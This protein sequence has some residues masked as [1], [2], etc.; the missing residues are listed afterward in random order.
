MV[1]GACRTSNL[2][3]R[4]ITPARALRLSYDLELLLKGSVTLQ[5]TVTGAMM[6]T[7]RVQACMN[8]CSRQ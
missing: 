4:R 6:L 3:D 7:Q 8:M 1:A 2:T 5:R